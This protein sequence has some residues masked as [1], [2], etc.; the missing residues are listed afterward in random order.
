VGNRLRTTS[1]T[2]TG[3]TSFSYQ[4]ARCNANGSACAGIYGAT[5]TSYGVGTADRGMAI[6]V[7]VTAKNAAGSTNATSTFTAI[8]A[9]KT[10][11]FN[12]VLRSGQEVT[13]PKG[14]SSI[15]AG[16]FTAKITGKTLRWTL[17]F[18]HL[19]S[20]PTVARLNKGVRG[21]SGA[22][23]KS[24][25]YTCRTPSHGTVTLTASQLDSLLSGHTYVNLVTKRNAHGEIRGQ[26]TRVN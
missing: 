9:V 8:E 19:S 24:L 1:G 12:A 15:A 17:T 21:T 11:S 25:C 14:T 7:T 4:W 16:H 26:I 22:A 23:F 6:R 13:R 18:S 5:G 3:A 2:W 20:R 10:A